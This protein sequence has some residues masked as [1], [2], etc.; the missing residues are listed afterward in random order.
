MSIMKQ[1]FLIVFILTLWAPPAAAADYV[2]W[3]GESPSNTNFPNKTWFSASTFENSR[4]DILSDGNWLTNADK[5]TGA[6]AFAQYTINVPAKGEYNLWARKFWKHGPFRW[7]FD[8]QPWQVCGRDIGLADTA[9]IRK[10]LC[11]N[12][13]YLGKVKLSKG[14]HRFELRLLAKEGEALTA[15]FDCFVLA[16]GQF[17]PRGKLKPG[18]KSGL[19]EPGWWAFEPAPDSFGKAMLDLRDL[20]EATAGE[21]GFV[22]RQGEKLVLGN[23]EPV[24]FWGVNC[25]GGILD[26]GRDTQDYLAR[27]LAKVGVNVVRIHSPAFDRNAPDPTRINKKR[28]ERLHYFVAALKK[29]G[30]YVN[31]SFY[32]PLWMDVKAGYRIPGYDTI[33][34]KKPFALLFFDPRMQRIYKSWAKT[35]L[36]AANPHTGLPLAKDPGVAII[37]I[38]NEDSFFFWTFSERNVPRAQM[39]KVEKLFGAWLARKYGS[40]NKAIA[41]WGKPKALKNDDPAKGTMEIRGVWFL[42]AKGHG[43]GAMRKRLSDQLRFLTWQQKRFYSSMIKFFREEIGAKSVISCSN[44]HTADPRILDGIERYTYTAGDIIDRHGYFGGSHEG[45]RA[46]YSVSAGD[47]FRDRAGVLEPD[48]LPLTVNQVG[49]YPHMISEIG[50]PNP[51]RFKAEFPVLSSAYACLQGLDGI[52]FFAVSGA[53]WEASPKKFPL[54]VP[55][56]L[57]QFPGTALM[58]RRGDVRQAE[59]VVHEVLD[60]EALYRFEGSAAV[61]VQSLDALRKANVPAGGVARGVKVAGIDPLAFYAGRVLRSFG[62]GRSNALLRDLTKYVD[63]NKKQIRTITGELKWDYGG[64][65]VTVDTP[66]SQCA[67]G[68]LQ[69]AGRIE[70]SDVAIECDN[71]F[72]AI[73]VVSLDAKPIASSRNILVQAVTEEKCYGWKVAGDKIASLGGYPLNVRNIDATVILKRGSRL[74]AVH[75]LDAHGR[76]RSTSKA[77][78][79]ALGVSIKLPADALYT[80][81]R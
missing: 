10:H 35:L 54:S 53:D 28:L 39:R 26:L 75:V 4:H 72:A 13:V 16:R 21:S 18:D 59:P 12:W 17:V 70:L 7:R 41:A 50:W 19:A 11:V 8:K 23:G 62:P 68:F 45:P 40:I 31:I 63:R 37:E 3:E 5:R 2:W 57:G 55:T 56:I 60:L 24:R 22:R 34:N 6:E 25:G 32:F 71:E 77:K 43:K 46:G 78:K 65:V 42:T 79:S 67:V 15:C 33:D 48:K 74:S 1:T 64:G 47:T 61:A 58:Y 44:W 69:R 27:R 36:G 29:Q 73:I 14:A 30:I 20:N 51:N 52:F 9:E 80:V 66:R 38:V 76:L 49:R 81:V